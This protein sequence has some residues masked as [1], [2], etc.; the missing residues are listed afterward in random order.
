[1][2][3]Y[4]FLRGAFSL[5]LAV[6]FAVVLFSPG[7]AVLAAEDEEAETK[8]W[9]EIDVQFP[10]AP[11]KE[12][13]TPFYVSAATNNDFFIDGSTLSVGEDGVVRY[14][15]VIQ[16]AGGARNVSYEGMRCLTRERRIYA[17]GR[18]D[19]SWSAA[20]NNEWVRIHDAAANRQYAALFLEYFCPGGVIV[21]N[22]EEARNALRLGG[23][24]EN[25]QR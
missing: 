20:R 24:P 15:L 4:S 14:V 16:T 5:P 17:S 13:L 10:P 19:G 25:K 8:P 6:C 12:L 7:R 23:H 2:N 21:R 18:L 1:M 3:K 9:Q 11:R 22:A